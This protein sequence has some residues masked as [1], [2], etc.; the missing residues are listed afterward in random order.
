MDTLMQDLRYAARALRRA[1]GFALVAILTLALG[2]GANT[3]IFSVVSGVLLQPLPFRDPA[4]LVVVWGDHNTIGH[5]VASLPDFQDW[6]TGNTTFAGMTGV[7]NAGDNLVV[8]GADAV[9]LRSARVTANFFTVLG[10]TPAL[11]RAFLPEEDTYG[12]HQVV[13]LSDA[14]WRRQFGANP[15]IVG[16]SIL[17][18]GTAYRVVGVAPPEM[19]QPQ[20][21]DLWSPLAFNPAERPPSRRGDFLFVIGRLK[22]GVTVAQAKT[23][24]QSIMSRLEREYPGTNQ[25]WSADVVPLHDELVGPVRPALLIFAGAVGLVLLIACANVANLMLARSAVREREVAVRLAMGAP[26]SRI[27]RQLLTESVLLALIGGAAGV[28]LAV[29]FVASLQ[30]MQL[31]QIPR[32]EEVRVNGVVLL[33]TLVV[34]VLTGLLFGLAPALRLTRPE[35]QGALKE[36]GRGAAGGTRTDRV[37]GALVLS[38]VAMALLLLVGAGLLVRSFQHLLQVEPGFRAENVLTF[39]LTLP[40]TKYADPEQT[41]ATQRMLRERLAALPGVRSVGM[42]SDLPMADGYGYL[43]F[44][45]QGQTQPDPGVVQDAVV[46]VADADYFTTMGIP[47]RRGQLFTGR[48]PFDTTTVAV[49]N[50]AL[51]RRFLKGR[52]P[53]GARITLGDGDAGPW[54]TVVGVVADTRL[55]SMAKE[56]YQ[57]IFFPAQQLVQRGMSFALRTAGDPAALAPA[58]RRAVA[59]LDPTVPVADLETME[60]RVS[61]VMAKPRVNLTLLGIFAAVALLLASVGIYGVVA[62]AVAQRTRELGIRVALGAS[63]RDVLRLVLRQGMTPVVVGLVLGLAVALLSTR[64]LTSILYGVRPTD[65]LTLAAVTILLGAIGFVASWLPARRAMRVDPM[66]ALRAE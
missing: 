3:G 19:T 53:I 21:V 65:P 23:E 43:T 50:E 11:G 66:I 35:L 4:R 56:P 41:Y 1:P 10:V 27:A 55:E 14:L 40:R 64:V 24:M 61:S 57:Q 12:S 31:S 54:A 17:L 37:R 52:D 13:V 18:N 42:T 26:R 29:W 20:G 7:A 22:D 62:Y 44:A 47:L 60:R 45:V 5:E 2:I 49:I 15:G 16:Q 36:G 8:P 25:G 30:T 48:E 38:Q 46:I 28:L 39:R 63:G 51:A 59:D 33:F 32:L 58:V 6:R 9:R 34:S